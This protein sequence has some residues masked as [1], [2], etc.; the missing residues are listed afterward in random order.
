MK[1]FTRNRIAL[2]SSAAL[3]LMFAGVFFIAHYR[4]KAVEND[5]DEMGD[6][7]AKG[8]FTER[9]LIEDA[10]KLDFLKSRDQRINK[11]P[12]ERLFAAFRYADML[13]AKKRGIVP[14]A[15]T[16]LIWTERGP[17]DIGG[18][19]RAILPDL[20]DATGKTVW[21]GSVGGGLWKTTDITQTNP[22]WTATNDFFNNLAVTCIAQNSTTP[23]TMYFG[24][25]EGWFNEDGLE[26]DGI[27]KSTDGGT[28]WNQLPNTDNS[29]ANYTFDYNQKILDYT[30]GGTEYLFACTYNGGVQRSKDGGTTWTKVLGS[31]ATATY[32]SAVDI[33]RSADGALFATIGIFVQD[34][35]YRS[36]DNGT[37]WTKLKTGLP[38]TNYNRIQLACA[39]SDSNRVYA[40]YQN[41]STYACLGIYKSTNA[42]TN[43]AAVTNP[44]IYGGSNFASTQA[45]YALTIGV[46]PNTAN[47]IIV[48]GLDLT[49]SANGGTSWTTISQW[50]GAGGYQYVHADHHAIVYD[51]RSSSKVYFGN[52]GG[53][54]ASTNATATTPTITS[55]DNSYNVTQFY[56]AAIYPTPNTN[57][58][59]AGAQDNG[60]IMFTT[61]GINAGNNFT[62]GDGAFDHIDDDQPNIQI[63]SYVY[64]NYYVTNNNWTSYSSIAFAGNVGQFIN[65]TDYDSRTNTLY[66]G[67]A[68]RKYHLVLNVGTTNTTQT[69]TIST[70]RGQVTAIRVS[71]NTRNRVFFGLDST[72]SSTYVDVY[73]TVCKVDNATS[74]NPTVTQIG[75]FTLA[76]GDYL[77]CIA[78][79]PG[80]DNH[81][82]VTFSNYGNQG[83]SIWETK[84][85]GTT[86]TSIAGNLPDMPIRSICFYPFNNTEAIIGTDLGVW[87]TDGINGT[88]TVWGESNTG[89]A[90][91]ST[92]WVD[93]RK[94][95]GTLFAA[96]HGRGL[97]TSTSFVQPVI[98]YVNTD[99]TISK[100]INT[101]STTDCRSYKDYSVPL[102][103]A[104]NASVAPQVKVVA[105]SNTLVAGVD[106][107]I[108]TSGA[109]TFSAAGTQNVTVRIYNTPNS[110]S[111]DT[112]NLGL[113][114]VNS[115]STNAIIT[116]FPFFNSYTFFI[117]NA[118]Q[119]I[120]PV[121]TWYDISAAP[122]QYVGPNRTVYL[123][124]S[125]T[126][127]N[128]IASVT[129][130][131]SSSLACFN[132]EVDRPGGYSNVAFQDNI[133][134]DYLA[135]KT[136][137]ITPA[138]GAST[139]LNYTITMYY[140]NAEI[141]TWATQ[142]GNSVANI[143]IISVDNHAVSAVTP[144]NQYAS[145]VE[146]W[147]TN[148]A[149]YNSTNYAFSATLYSVGTVE[150]FGVGAPDIILPVSMLDLTGSLVKGNGLLNWKTSTEINNKGFEVQ[151]ST[152]GRTFT[153][154]GFV[155]GNG[156]TNVPHN[157]SFTDN[158]VLQ[159]MNYYRLQQMDNDGHTAYSNTIT[160]AKNNI[161]NTVL[162]QQNPFVSKL[163][164]IIGGTLSGN[165]EIRIFDIAGRQV[166]ATNQP[167]Q[168]IISINGA[169]WPAG[170]YIATAIWNNKLYTFKVI[171]N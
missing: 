62:G 36:Y 151:K 114:L 158:F 48:G 104:E 26:G 78:V 40:L 73:A 113:S 128:I 103:L 124:D 12:S 119:S 45:W 14:N 38:T 95:D 127:K 50:Y 150:G 61:A 28:T 91:V 41:A 118:A 18:R 111:A 125:S 2:I 10:F 76:G 55:K 166:Y 144:T 64:G 93:Y 37:T 99:T 20:N 152:D 77:S 138:N 147:P 112:L 143:K 107:D 81:I 59:L 130:N 72:N 140:T 33:E 3:L 108:I 121:R 39:A 47:R 157:Y 162:V 131:S 46:D 53:V 102:Q 54:F 16:G 135:S 11:V 56:Q 30:S 69:N 67:D 164:L 13:K 87:S 27:W 70:F 1:R 98:S 142:S 19:T 4:E 8:G 80:N 168:N 84:N 66:G 57:Y 89:L 6:P 22:V 96:T 165:V 92:D 85:G 115:S 94:S 161:S 141:N 43:W 110:S 101:G 88:S 116:P 63:A 51:P 160:I 74:T 71:P 49:A 105:T 123:Y 171:K 139:G 42:G 58:A 52:D 15:L 90:R 146:A 35:I 129:N 120:L 117:T 145:S 24:T 106:Y 23:T 82:L 154:I 100:S 153:N 156:T 9:E 31:G 68:V 29:V 109:I 136:L 159:P 133:P 21:A 163:N 17:S 60:N 65:P 7:D 169:N 97:F 44:T 148:T 34:G 132:V 167:A 79:E 170:T 32:N 5:K 122:T 137:L 86:W 134:A 155:N 126:A 25:G 149:V 83:N 75:K